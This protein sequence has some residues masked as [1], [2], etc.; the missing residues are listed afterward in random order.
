MEPDIYQRMIA[1]LEKLYTPQGLKLFER[2]ELRY[3][4]VT[5]T[6][7][8]EALQDILALPPPRFRLYGAELPIYN[9][10]IVAQLQQNG[11]RLYDGVTFAFDALELNPLRIY[12]KLGSYYDHLATCVSLEQELLENPELPYRNHLHSLFEPSKLLTSGAGRSAA[13]GVS[14]LIVFKHTDGYR[15]LFTRR[16]GKTA[17]KPNSFHVMPAF[18][19][20]PSGYNYFPQDWNLVTQIT[21][22]YLEELFGVS[23]HIT[24]AEKDALPPLVHLNAMLSDSR[25]TLHFTGVVLN[26][27]STH[28]SITALMM[29]H[30]EGWYQTLPAPN[31]PSWETGETYLLPL[32]SDAALL[33]ALPENAPLSM[34]CEGAAALWQGVDMARKLLDGRH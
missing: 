22:E 12:A 17:H 26:L 30:D 3:P 5:I 15:A 9:P 4:F 21:R 18:M 16:S 28:V 31:Q 10:Q 33:A 23:E 7:K 6:S 8:G 14:T 2:H 32:D 11:A 29:I 19:L 25:A 20:Q 13:L 27:M 24:P 1:T 34:S